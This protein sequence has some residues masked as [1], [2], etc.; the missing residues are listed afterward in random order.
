[1]RYF[2]PLFSRSLTLSWALSL[3]KSGSYTLHPRLASNS[4]SCYLCLL[5][6]QEVRWAM[7]PT[8]HPVSV[9]KEI[10]LRVLHYIH[11]L[12][13]CIDVVQ[14]L[15]KLHNSDSKGVFVGKQFHIQLA[16]YHRVS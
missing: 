5:W 2:L 4:Q 16:L 11:Y 1:M 8:L 6:S 13:R 12:Q 10:L 15:L 3:Y 9:Q 7:C 14:A